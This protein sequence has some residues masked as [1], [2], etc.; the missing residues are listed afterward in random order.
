MTVGGRLRGTTTLWPHILLS[1][2]LYYNYILKIRHTF[3]YGS[4][5]AHS[6]YKGMLMYTVEHIPQTIRNKKKV[7]SHQMY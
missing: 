1:K 4:G 6:L 3:L 2:P 7:I 5:R